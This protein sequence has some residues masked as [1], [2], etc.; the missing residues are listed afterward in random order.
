MYITTFA[1]IFLVSKI[2]IFHFGMDVYFMYSYFRNKIPMTSISI[3]NI[4][5]IIL[6]T[7]SLANNEANSKP[8]SIP[9]VTNTIIL[10]FAM[11][12]SKL[13]VIIDPV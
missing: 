1:F 12:S 8:K 2:L 6:N 11:I 13:H 3:K 5:I 4:I 7:L 10:L 9:I